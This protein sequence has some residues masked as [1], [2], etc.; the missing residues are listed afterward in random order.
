MKSQ[1][2]T[3]DAVEPVRRRY[4]DACGTAHALELIGERWA[5]LVMREMMYGPRRFGELRAGLPGISANVLTQRLEGLERS[6]LVI[7]RRLPP[8]ASVWVYALTDWGHETRPLIQQLGKWAARS[9]D[10]DP[11]LPLSAASLM[12]SFDTMLDRAG[13]GDR[14][15]TIGFRLGEEHFIAR[16][17][18]QG[19]DVRRGDVAGADLVFSGDPTAI[20]AI[21]YGDA[22]LDLVAL[23]GEPADA[24]WFASLFTL[25]DKATVPGRG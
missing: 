12:M 6:G 20:A 17:S 13:V 23:E 2:I 19:F 9:P 25:P 14:V 10:H 18:N 21:V 1:K 3:S 22:P 8:P 16:L 15:M 11:T 4:D 24:R 5:L 7:R